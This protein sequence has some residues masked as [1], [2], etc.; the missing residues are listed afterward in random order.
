MIQRIEYLGRMAKWREKQPVKA[1]C[2]VRRCGKTTLLAQYID[3]LKRSGVKE[4]QI[5]YV[6]LEPPETNALLDYRGLYGY[7]KKQ[8]FNPA[9]RSDRTEVPLCQDTFTYIFIDDIQMCAGYEKAVEGLLSIRQV[10]IYVTAS[11]F[12]LFSRVPYVDIK[13]LPL[14]FAESLLFTKA[15]S[16]SPA[17]PSDALREFS[18]PNPGGVPMK[19]TPLITGPS[20]AAPLKTGPSRIER[21]LPRQKARVEKILQ[22][23][24]FNDYL[25]FGGFPFTAV[26]G[27]D[28][29]LIRHYVEGIYNTILVKDA[30][31]R[32]G[33]NNIP[34]L[35]SIARMMSRSAGRPL[36]SKRI[37]TAIG[38]KG[39][40]TSTNTV[41]TYMRALISACVFYHIGRFDVKAGKH[42]KTLGRYYISDTG[43]G[44][45]LLND[46]PDVDGQLETV[47]CQELLRRGLRVYT[48]KYGNDEINF[49]AFGHTTARNSQA[50]AEPAAGNEGVKTAYFQVA[51][52][53][54]DGAVLDGKLAPLRRINDNH[55]KY[56]LS[57]DET[58]ARSNYNGII[59]RNLI[60]WLL[61][62]AQ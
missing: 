47:V 55:P 22:M 6:A 32:T 36:T 15:R 58:P 21:R 37:T 30:A 12:R 41:E 2:G 54:R 33:V 60:E 42:L 8:L 62:P 52:S 14:S 46:S 50:H 53:V 40:K 5:I 29:A 49:V 23:E 7:I 45:L 31:W 51:S 19:I 20:N 1:V 17:V 43:M 10:D 24:T 34:L 28:A 61:D 38:S 56:I 25:C 26:L 27:G 48:G 9:P 57:L 16:G 3:W 59:Q 13:M 39:K 44:N 35:E 18:V 4:T 11:D